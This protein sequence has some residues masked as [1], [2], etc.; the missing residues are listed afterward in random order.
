MMDC[1][2]KTNKYK[3]PL[4][5]IM[6]HTALGTSFCIGFAFL[7][8]E[9]EEDFTWVM[10]HLKAL[11][12][13]LGLKDPEVIVTDRDLALMNAIA[14]VFA[15]SANLL[16]VWHVNT[17]VL[18]NCKPA[19]D[20]EEKWKEFEAAWQQVVNADFGDDFN[21]AWRILRQPYGKDYEAEVIYLKDTWLRRHR[22]RFCKAWTNLVTHFNTTTTS[23]VEGGHRVLKSVLKTSTG[24]LLTV[25][26]GIELILN[27]QYTAW[28]HKLAQEKM[29]VA[30]RLPRDLMRDLIG[31]VSPY[32]LSKVYDQYTKVK[33]ADKDPE[34]HELKEC[35]RLFMTTMGLPCAHVIKAN[36]EAEEQKLLLEDVHP[37]WR[38]KKSETSLLTPTNNFFSDSLPTEIYEAPPERF[39]DSFSESSEAFDDFADDSELLPEVGTLLNDRRNRIVSQLA[40]SAA[41][42]VSE[43]AELNDLLNIAEPS[44]AKAKGRPRGSQNKKGI[45]TRA[46]KKAAR[47]TKRDLSG[48]EHVE[49]EYEARAKR[50]KKNT[51]GEATRGRRGRGG[52]GRGGGGRGGGGRAATT[53]TSRPTTPMTTRAG[54]NASRPMELSSNTESESEVSDKGFSDDGF[55]NLP[56]GIFYE[57]AEDEGFN[58]SKMGDEDLQDEWMQ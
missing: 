49:R 2:Y 42:L 21:T 47:F 18:K 55:N 52:G 32:A 28:T 6:G 24:D 13:H 22:H 34:E 58:A 57:D 7:E 53:A 4:L 16:C 44:V 30:Y 14:T 27:R 9:E 36:M 41:F 35:G 10:E 45:M 19:F 50:A 48:F 31:R 11:Y 15:S 39:D 54:A 43:D 29:K 12:R 40:S 46:E 17:N 37:H 56:Q 8:K 26:D 3:M 25:V 20:T 5:I 33:R 23:R 1:T 38:F 51:T